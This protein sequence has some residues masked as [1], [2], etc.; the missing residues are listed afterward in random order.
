MKKVKV[1][2]S[3]SCNGEVHS[4]GTELEIDE[5]LYNSIATLGIVTEIKKNKT[6][7]GE[8]HNWNTEGKNTNSKK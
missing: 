8:L 5:S 2:Q 7:K 3:W 1:M 6:E 4:I